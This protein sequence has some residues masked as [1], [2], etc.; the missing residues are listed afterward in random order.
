MKLHRSSRRQGFTLVELLVVIGIIALLISILL[1]ALNRAREQANRVKCA[2]NLRQIGLAMLMYA[3]AERNGGFPRTIFN[4]TAANLSMNTT[5]YGIANS[6]S[7]PVKDNNVPASFF[8]VLKTQDITS[9]VFICPSS[10]AERGFV[11]SGSVSIQNSSNWKSIKGNLSYSINVMFPTAAAVGGGWKWNN[12]LSSDYA[13]AADINPGTTGG[14]NP[15]NNVTLP[16]HADSRINMAAANSNNHKND[17]QNV[18]YADG[19]VEFNSSPY[20]GSVRQDA[21]FKDNI[22]TADPG[23][24][25]HEKGTEG[26]SSL[27]IDSLDSV[28]LPDDDQP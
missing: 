22:Y 3:N 18:L 5:G 24:M 14:S 10:Q 11:D 17:G 4:P 19:H 7:A 13:I 23:S 6:F 8:L 26:T 16:T 28:L 15:T 25:P 20:C 9:E 1:P 21:G 2:S 12:T 27:P